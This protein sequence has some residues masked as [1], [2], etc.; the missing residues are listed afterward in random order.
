MSTLGDQIRKWLTIVCNC[1]PRRA[2]S[3]LDAAVSSL[4]E[5]VC[6]ETSRTL[7]MLRLISSAAAIC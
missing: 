5:A 1:P 2:S 7:T 3:T 4:A 6:S